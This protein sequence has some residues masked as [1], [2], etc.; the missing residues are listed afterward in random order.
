MTLPTPSL[1][2]RRFQDLVDEAKR[3][4]PRYCP[5]W[6]DHN[7]SDPGIALV[8][9][10]AWMTDLT[11]YRLNKVPDRLYTKFLE[12]LGI[13]LYAAAPARTDILFWLSGPQT[14]ELRIPAGTQ[15][16]TVR[17]ERE[18]SIIFMTN[19]D[20]LVV[21]PEL[22]ACVTES[23]GSFADKQSDLAVDGYE[24]DVFAS[25]EPG[26]AFYLGFA[27]SLAGNVVRLDIQ[28]EVQS[29]GVDP[30]K[31][32]WVWEAMGDDRWQACRLLDDQTLALNRNGPITLIVPPRHEAVT[33]G[34]TRAYW[35]RCRL[36]PSEAG[37]PRLAASPK[38]SSLQARSLGAMAPAHQGQPAGQE[39]L[40][41][42]DGSPGQTFAVR[43]TPALPR[44]GGE[45]VRVITPEESMDW[46]E[47]PDFAHSAPDD[48]H[49]VWDGTTGE[50]R[51]GPRI[52]Y[53]DGSTR[54]YGAVP[55]VD[56]E[57]VVTGYR[58]GGGT[59][60]NVGARTVKWL[61]SSLPFIG[62]VENLDAASGGVD[63]ET[64]AN[65]K[66]RGPQSLRTGGRAVTATD[67]ERLATEAHPG[68]ARARCLAP[69]RA[70]G[71][72]RVLIVPRVHQPP[73]Q[74]RFGDLALSQELLA[75]ARAYLDERRTLTTAVEL[76][77]PDYLG[78]AVHAVLIAEPG[79][80]PHTIRSRA[81]AALYGYINPI[82]GGQQG[83]GWPFG[84]PLTIGEV[85]SLLAGLDG[86]SGVDEVRLELPDAPDGRGRHRQRVELASDALFAS[87]EHQIWVNTTT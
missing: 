30:T 63:A 5:E 23:N 84:R 66:L 37:Q 27:K 12:L 25:L 79:G 19:E 64:V 69:A 38:I 51:F 65:A 42:S 20:R 86:V 6:T 1:D 41:R 82:V 61:K 17:T 15:V 85:H 46:T 78:V 53:P 48:R 55:P 71:P 11:L 31:P 75:Q 2:D 28:A 14:E 62:Q 8:E 54:Q 57:I 67:F 39:Q 10:F 32:P 9:L 13:T 68:V 77:A 35:V 16:G 81:L 40:G 33:V 70:G 50:I 59:R 26:D 18:E 7:L 3:L 49:F 36:L 72:V 45:T 4:I 74:L 47:V 83:T 52:R 24:V 60:G 76:R 21:I 80:E 34:A 73:E 43:R 29:A 56:G 22:T 87:H 58:Y 44:V